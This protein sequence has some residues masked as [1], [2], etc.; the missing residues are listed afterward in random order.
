MLQLFESSAGGEKVR[1]NLL[2]IPEIITLAFLMGK[3]PQI[4]PQD[5]HPPIHAEYQRVTCYVWTGSRTASGVYP[6]EGMCASSRAN[7]GRTA[8]VY[9]KDGTL[10]GSYLCTDTGGAKR[11][12]RGEVDIYR[13][14]MSRAKEW[15]RTYGDYCYVRW[16]D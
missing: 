6:A 5:L 1:M 7:I 11:L 15:I 4:E 9:D 8:Y 16:E 14:D 13:D 3:E 10:I 12:K 2:W